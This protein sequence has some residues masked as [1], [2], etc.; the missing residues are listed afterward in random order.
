VNQPLSGCFFGHAD[1]LISAIQEIL[2]DFE[3][4]TF[5]KVFDKWIRKLEQWIEIPGE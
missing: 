4:P 5:T 3:K 1:D 2:D